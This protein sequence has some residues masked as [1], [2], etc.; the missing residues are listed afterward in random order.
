[1]DTEADGR[2]QTLYTGSDGGDDRTGRPYFHYVASE[3]G[4]ITENRELPPRR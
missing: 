1:V 3:H 2:S 4:L